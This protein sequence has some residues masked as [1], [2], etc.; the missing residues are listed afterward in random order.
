V[1]RV[2]QIRRPC[3]VERAWRSPHRYGSPWPPWIADR[4]RHMLLSTMQRTKSTRRDLGRREGDAVTAAHLE[5]AARRI[6]S[7]DIGPEFR[8]FQASIKYD[9]VLKTG[10]RVPPKLLFAMAA[11][12][13][14]G[15]QLGP[16]DF[17]GGEGTTCFHVIR[18]FG[19]DVV[20]KDAQGTDAT[21]RF[22]EWYGDSALLNRHMARERARGL[23]EAKQTTFVEEHGRLRCERCGFDPEPL[24]GALGIVCIEVHDVTAVPIGD[25]EWTPPGLSELECLCANCHCVAHERLVAGRDLRG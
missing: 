8:H 1:A 6:R 3:G 22:A 9:V 13:A 4:H 19:N 18:K 2:L 11:S 24:H 23:V 16:Y 10:E 15:R 21:A 12:E 17:N 20:P 5:R 7:G 14:L 25:E